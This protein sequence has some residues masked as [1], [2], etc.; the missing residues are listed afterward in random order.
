MTITDDGLVLGATL[1]APL[2]RD[3]RGMPALVIDGNEGRILA[4][5]A[6]AYG[7]MVD[8]AVLGNIRR[9]A[10]MGPRRALSRSNPSCP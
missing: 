7:R 3:A 1:L 5:L 8:P 10:R 4:L 6:I 2:R 9:A